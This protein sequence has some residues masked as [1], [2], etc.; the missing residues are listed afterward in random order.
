MQFLQDALDNLFN[1]LIETQDSDEYD[2]LV[3]DALV[4]TIDTCWLEIGGYCVCMSVDAVVF[5]L[6]CH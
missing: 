6:G 2:E 5:Y 1:I 3:F 4:S